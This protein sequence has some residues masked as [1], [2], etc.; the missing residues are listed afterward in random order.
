MLLTQEKHLI[1]QTQRGNIK[2][3]LIYPNSYHLGMSSLG[4]QII[5]YELCKNPNVLC[6]RVFL[7]NQEHQENN[8]PLFSYESH[9]PLKNFDL[10]AFSV[11]FESD[12]FNI[13]K[14]LQLARIPCLAKKRANPVER[15]DRSFPFVIAGGISVSYNPEPI[16]DFVDLFVIGEAESV[17]H[18]LMDKFYDWKYSGTGKIEL[19]TELGKLDSVY[20]PSFYDVKYHADGTI[21]S[22]KPN[23]KF[24]S[25]VV[26]GA[27]IDDIDKIRSASAI[28]TPN[29]EFSNVYLIEI[30]RGCV[31]NCNFCV[32]K[33]VRS[34]VRFRSLE[35]VL[36]LAEQ[37]VQFTDRIGL[38]GA[39]IS[40]HPKIDEIAKRL[41][42]LGFKISTASL[43]V[44][45]VTPTLLDALVRSE[46][47]TITIAPEAATERLKKIIN[48]RVSQDKLHFVIEEALKRG[49]FNI[50]LYFMVGVPGET[51]ADI[52]AIV[53]MCRKIRPILLK[54]ARKTLVMPQLN[55]T[56]SP[57]VPKPRTPFETIAM[58][59]YKSIS[60]KLNFLRKELGKIGGVKMSSASARLAHTQAVLSRGD[61]RLGRVILDV[62]VKNLSWKQ[63]LRK[64][65]LKADFYTLRERPDAEIF[66]WR[67]IT[68]GRLNN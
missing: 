31:W 34:P 18:Q 44:E 27:V 28:L 11:S 55:L 9:I 51:Q 64:H 35:S 60:R 19:L 45:T 20:I 68:N 23:T 47:S 38:I 30:T 56:I 50:R 36:E 40:D 32:L 24:S 14:I 29:T 52:D 26:H 42:N 49:L 48:K 17:I 41:V 21:R 66:P 1:R 6:E 4:F 37:A 15:N 3:A 58:D 8:K 12:Y 16:S 43:R 62:S 22:I 25:P 7:P 2:I 46:Q 61:R 39:S 57:L 67:H 53:G 33:H 59:S 5:Y 65:N 10:I 13:P 54:Y 63:A